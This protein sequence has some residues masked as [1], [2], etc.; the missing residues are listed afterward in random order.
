MR[1]LKTIVSNYAFM[2]IFAFLPYGYKKWR[3]H[4]YAVRHKK[5]NENKTMHCTI[6]LLYNIYHFI[7]FDNLFSNSIILS[8]SSCIS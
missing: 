6:V 3:K 8:L 2:H 7:S 1:S 5:G 4:Q